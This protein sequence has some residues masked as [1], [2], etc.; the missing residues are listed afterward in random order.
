MIT[1]GS[2][3]ASPIT[4]LWNVFTHPLYWIWWQE[5]HFSEPEKEDVPGTPGGTLPSK[6]VASRRRH[7]G[8]MKRSKN[9][10][11][12]DSNRPETIV[13]S[14]PPYYPALRLS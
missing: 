2:F 8:R 5:A 14:F 13:I 3:F 9:A 1:E 10:T 12:I 6:P 7:T 4:V 11:V